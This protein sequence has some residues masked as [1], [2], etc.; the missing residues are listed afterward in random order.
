[1]GDDNSGMII[2]GTMNCMYSNNR[3]LF[4]F[5]ENSFIRLPID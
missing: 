3:L 4:L 5:I 1:M 2:A